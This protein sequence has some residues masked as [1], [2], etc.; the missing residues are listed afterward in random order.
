MNWLTNFVR[1]KIRAIVKK[2]NVPDNLWHRCPACEQMIFHRD[3]VANLFVCTQCGHHMRISADERLKMLFDDGRYT[4]IELP[5]TVQDPLK[6]RDQKRYGDRVR[7]ARGKTGHKDAIIVA[8][9]RMGG[10]PVVVAAF[11]FRFLGGSMGIAVGEG[12]VAAARLAVLQQAP[13][14][15]I[16]ASGGARMQEG[17]LSLMQMPR[18]TVAVEMVREAGLPYIVLLTDPT[19][20]GVSAS[21]AMLGD[22]QIAEPGAV[23]GF[24]GARVIENTIREKLPEGFQRAEYLLEHGMVDMVVQRR[25]LRETLIRIIGILMNRK[26]AADVVPL[27]DPDD[28]PHAPAKGPKGDASRPPGFHR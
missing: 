7:E 15:A 5:E 18:S 20:G 3:L 25:E 1:P 14:I 22:I 12:L 6:F 17:I 10:L 24:A 28:G 23:I 16:P 2:E 9:G 19:T 13:L 27:V 11:D 4:A 26:P 21:F 8:H